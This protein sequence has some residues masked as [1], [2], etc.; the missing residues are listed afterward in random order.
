MDSPKNSH[1]KAKKRIL[2][3][4]ARTMNYGILYSTLDNFQLIGYTNSDFVGSIDDI[5]STSRYAF[6]FLIG[7]IA[8]E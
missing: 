6:N 7:F 5:K 4:I 1:W 2:R 3:Y 8:H